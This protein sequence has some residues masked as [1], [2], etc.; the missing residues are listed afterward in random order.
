MINSFP[1]YS[2][3]LFIISFHLSL[4]FLQCLYL[5]AQSFNQCP[6]SD[7]VA[8]NF[9]LFTHQTK[10]LEFH[11]FYALTTWGV[12]LHQEIRKRRERAM[13]PDKIWNMKPFI[14]ICSDLF[15]NFFH[16]V[17]SEVLYFILNYVFCSS[18]FSGNGIMAELLTFTVNF[19]LNLLI[20][21]HAFF[22]CINDVHFNLLVQ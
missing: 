6:V 1:L 4:F 16:E 17:K 7:L 19:T 11:L 22:F 5:F 13:S 8:F 12:E 3:L 9:L 15:C 18:C 2:Q 20:E 14:A 10:L 21:S